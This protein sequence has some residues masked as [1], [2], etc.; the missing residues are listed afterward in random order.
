MSCN[1][2]L[3]RDSHDNAICIAT[4]GNVFISR[5]VILL[6]TIPLMD[7]VM[8]HWIQRIQWNLFKKNASITVSL[9]I[10]QI[11]KYCDRNDRISNDESLGST[12]D[13]NTPNKE[14]RITGNTSFWKNW[15]FLPLFL[16][17]VTFCIFC[18]LE[19]YFYFSYI[20]RWIVGKNLSNL[21]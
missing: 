20:P 4:T 3:P 18:C 12:K 15:K 2:Y 7:F 13:L 5:W 17:K 10:F 16:D 1:R 21:T 6:A 9:V 11:I 14:Y 8:I 19:I